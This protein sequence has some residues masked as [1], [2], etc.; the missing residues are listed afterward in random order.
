MSAMFESASLFNQP[1]NNWD[2]SS[3][4]NMMD[5]FN[6]AS[7]FNQA[8]DSWDVSNVVSMDNMLDNCGMSQ[9]NYENLLIGWESLPSLQSSVTFG[10]LNMIYQIGSAANTARTNIITNYSWSIVGD[11]AVP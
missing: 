4:T 8:L 2:V 5:M 6:S 11:I 9:T 7:N 1:V 10:A 3:V